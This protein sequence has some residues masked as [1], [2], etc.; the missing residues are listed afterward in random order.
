LLDSILVAEGPAP[1]ADGRAQLRQEKVNEAIV[2]LRGSRILLAEDNEINQELAME[3][4]VNNGILVDVANNG[5][6][7]LKLLEQGQYDGVLMDCQMPVMDGYETARE[8]RRHE[9]WR[10]LPI[11]AMT[12]N[13][14]TGD[15]QN[16]LDAGMNDHIAKPIDVSRM[17]QTI[18]KWVTPA[19]P[20]SAHWNSVTTKPT[21]AAEIPAIPEIPG[22]DTA[23]GLQIAEGNRTLYRRLLVKFRVAHRHFLEEFERAQ[24]SDDPGAALRLAHSL[25]GVAAN[26]GLKSV[27]REARELEAA[28]SAGPESP[29]VK[30]ALASLVAQLEPILDALDNLDDA[31]PAQA[32]A[33]VDAA[34]IAVEVRR[35]RKLVEDSDTEA[36]AVLEGLTAMAGPAPYD[37]LLK[38][39]NKALDAYDFDAALVEIK[40]LEQALEES[41]DG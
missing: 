30:Q 19:V 2:G 38:R 28:F 26:L 31:I 33:T 21:E 27:A 18:A 7:A 24:R 5:L 1:R 3:L 39:L 11:I 40:S 37:A 34:T 12:A 9:K 13:A 8:I 20:A 16:S 6:E 10:D 4:L 17:F 35:L 23:V 25:K 41:A 36:G 15:R 29:G 32:P 14:M 22:L